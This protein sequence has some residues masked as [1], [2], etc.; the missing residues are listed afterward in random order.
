MAVT[1]K[2]GLLIRVVCVPL[3]TC[4]L[5]SRVIARRPHVIAPGLWAEGESNVLRGLDFTAGPLPA[6]RFIPLPL[7]RIRRPM[8]SAFVLVDRV[9]DSVNNIPNAI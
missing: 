4:K 7:Y 3:R 2:T 8:L 5:L 1:G 6:Q 9:F